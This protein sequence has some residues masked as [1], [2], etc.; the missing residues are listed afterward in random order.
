MAPTFSA[1]T[2]RMYGRLPDFMQAADATA[3][4]VPSDYPLKRF[5]SLWMDKA[6]DVE[7]L[8]DR[9]AFATPDEGG[10]PGATCDLVDPTTADPS[11]LAWQAQLVGVGLVPG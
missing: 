2:E 11:W 7:A 5:I 3:G 10:E 1:A 9:F 8:I 6:G 4:V